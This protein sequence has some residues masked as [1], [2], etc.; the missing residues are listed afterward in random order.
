MA[1]GRGLQSLIPPKNPDD[2]TSGQAPS[3]DTPESSLPQ[4]EG[5]LASGRNKPGDEFFPKS[6]EPPR[7][8]ARQAPQEGEGASLEQTPKIRQPAEPPNVP[9]AF[10]IA[11]SGQVHKAPQEGPVSNL[12]NNSDDQTTQPYVYEPQLP[13]E[14]APLS[15]QAPLSP[16][17]TE[18]ETHGYTE[19]P[20]DIPMPPPIPNEPSAPQN[21]IPPSTHGEKTT[22]DT[23]EKT[24]QIDKLPPQYKE[25]IFHLE[26]EKISPN[27]YQPR[28][29]HNEGELQELAASIREYGILQPL[30]V[31]RIEHETPEGTQ[32]EYQLIAGERR[33]EASKLAGLERVPAIV[34]EEPKHEREKLEMALIENI[35]R[36]DLNPLDT[37]RAYA[38]LQDKFGLSQREVAQ[39][40]GKSRESIS[41]SVRL[42]QLPREAQLALAEGKINESQARL[43]LQTENATDQKEILSK[44]MEH[45]LTVRQ[46][47][48]L[49]DQ[50][51]FGNTTHGLMQSPSAL[52]PQIEFMRKQLEESLGARVQVVKKG[53]QGKI[54]IKF[55][56]EE[57]LQGLIDKLL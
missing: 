21:N 34:K 31:T 18:E 53:Q 36:S 44:V 25:P 17:K 40:L 52:D 1:L 15:K 32:T 38:K 5:G 6:D 43:L 27:P 48:D 39:R 26:V 51:K 45:S 33:L 19:K 3:A 9:A 47:K 42:L 57:E 29:V 2:E 41:N 11:D 35:Q 50:S 46:T 23:L 14:D 22:T 49:V 10:D 12:Q 8:T 13:K 56:S 20:Q 16:P 55:F 4:A 37:A 24:N 28:Q 30:V 54:T 7:D